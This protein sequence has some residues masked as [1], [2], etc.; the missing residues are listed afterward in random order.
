MART[1]VCPFLVTV[2]LKLK[3][4]ELPVARI[5][6]PYLNLV[7]RPRQAARGRGNEAN[8]ASFM[9]APVPFQIGIKSEIVIHPLKQLHAARAKRYLSE[10]N[11][12]ATRRANQQKRG[13]P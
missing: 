9:Y 3:W 7:P 4:P 13:K 12:A 11:R 6:P 8:A 10:E 1:K 2:D 5:T